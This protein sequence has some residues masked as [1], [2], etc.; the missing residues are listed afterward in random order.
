MNVHGLSKSVAKSTQEWLRIIRCSA[1][2]DGRSLRR[3]NRA[4]SQSGRI[5]PIQQRP[6][7]D[8]QS[9]SGWTGPCR[10][11]SKR[12]PVSGQPFGATHATLRQPLC[13][14]R[15]EPSISSPSLKLKLGLRRVRG[16]ALFQ[17]HCIMSFGSLDRLRVGKVLLTSCGPFRCD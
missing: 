10:F 9:C 12:L 5:A 17:V 8:V 4:R 7:R 1:F 11:Q 15:P 3:Y 16:R 6:D 14:V 2:S 13:L